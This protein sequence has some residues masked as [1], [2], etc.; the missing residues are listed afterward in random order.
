V[1]SAVVVPFASTTSLSLNRH[2]GFSWQKTTATVKVASASP[3]PVTGVVTVTVNGK[4]VDVT[5]TAKDNGSVTYT[6]PKLRAGFY[7]VKASFAG[8]DSV[9]GSKSSTSLV[10][11]VF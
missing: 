2:V 7:T 10:W 8:S 1:S 5:L 4:P 6:L 11:I 9:A 3:A